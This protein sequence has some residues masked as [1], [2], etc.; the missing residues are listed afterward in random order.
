MLPDVSWSSFVMSSKTDL[1]CRISQQNVT[2]DASVCRDF[3]RNV[4]KRGRRCKFTHPPQLL[5]DKIRRSE[6]I[7]CHDYQNA[8]C[9]RP[10][11]K[12]LHYSREEEEIFRLTGR[13]PGERESTSD[14]TLPPVTNAK[15]P[16]C[17]DYLSG[18][19]I[20]GSSC[21]YRHIASHAKGQILQ[22]E[23][24]TVPRGTVSDDTYCV[25]PDFG[26]VTCTSVPSCALSSAITDGVSFGLPPSTMIT[27]SIS[28]SVSDRPSFSQS[29]KHST[30][31]AFSN[32]P[33]RTPVGDVCFG[34]YT[35]ATPV[36][37]VVGHCGLPS[38]SLQHTLYA[39]SPS[40][41][42]YAPLGSVPSTS[43]PV[44]CSSV[45]AVVA[46][47][48]QHPAVLQ[49]P[50]AV[51]NP[52]ATFLLSNTVSPI[53]SH[54]LSSSSSVSSAPALLTIPF[55][56]FECNSSASGTILS[57]HATAD[58]PAIFSNVL[59]T[60]GTVTN[61]SGAYFP[62]YNFLRITPSTSVAT[63]P[64]FPGQHVVTESTPVV[65]SSSTTAVLAAAAAAGYLAQHLPTM[66][67]NTGACTNASSDDT[68]CGLEVR[69]GPQE[70]LRV[71]N[72]QESVALAAAANIPAVSAA[73]AAAAVAAAKAF[74]A[75]T[76][77]D[78]HTLCATLNSQVIVATTV[79]SAAQ[80][81]A[82]AAVAATAAVTHSA[83]FFQLSRKRNSTTNFDSLKS[84][85]AGFSHALNSSTSAGAP[86]CQLPISQA[87]SDRTG[88]SPNTAV[89]MTNAAAAAAMAAAAVSV[90]AKQ[91]Q[92]LSEMQHSTFSE[93]SMNASPRQPKNADCQKNSYNAEN[94]RFPVT[95]GAD[96]FLES[97]R[98]P[99]SRPCFGYFQRLRDTSCVGALEDEEDDEDP[100]VSEDDPDNAMP[101]FPS[102][103]SSLHDCPRKLCKLSDRLDAVFVSP[104]DESRTASDTSPSESFD[105][106]LSPHVECRDAALITH[107]SN[108]NRHSSDRQIET[109]QLPSLS[110]AGRN[111]SVAVELGGSGCDSSR[112]TRLPS[113]QLCPR[114]HATSFARLV[115]D[116]V[117]IFPSRSP[118]GSLRRSRSMTALSTSVLKKLGPIR[119]NST[120]GF[121]MET[122]S[123]PSKPLSSGS[124]TNPQIAVTV[125]EQLCVVPSQGVHISEPKSRNYL[126]NLHDCANLKNAPRCPRT[127]VSSSKS[128]RLSKTKSNALS[129]RLNSGANPPVRRRM[130]DR[131]Q[132]IASPDS[133]LTEDYYQCGMDEVEYM[134]TEDEDI[135]EL[136]ARKSS[137]Q[138]S[139]TSQPA[140]TK[141]SKSTGATISSNS[142][143]SSTSVQ[144]QRAL[145]AENS[146]LRRK[147]FELLRQRG[148]LRAANEILLEQNA[149][150]RHSSK[151]ASAVARMAESATKIIEAHSKSRLAKP[152]AHPLSSGHLPSTTE[153]PRS[154]DH[155]SITQAA[156]AAAA[157]V[158]AAQQRPSIPPVR[159]AYVSSP[160]AATQQ[161]PPAIISSAIPGAI[162][163]SSH[164]PLTAM[165]IQPTG[166]PQTYCSVSTQLS[167]IGAQSVDSRQNTV[168]NFYEHQM[169][170]PVGSIPVSITNIPRHP[171]MTVPSTIQVCHYPISSS[172]AVFSS[173]PQITAVTPSIVPIGA[174]NAVTLLVGR[175]PAALAP[176][177]TALHLPNNTVATETVSVNF[178]PVPCVY[179][180]TPSRVF[181]SDKQYPPAG[182]VTKVEHMNSEDKASE[183]QTDSSTSGSLIQQ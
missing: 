78:E 171:S 71:D 96:V 63:L 57:P 9:R 15:P 3:L 62:S 31:P 183:Q 151:R 137:L 116:S 156:A 88:L 4:C 119:P 135:F 23:T 56:H 109:S 152:G 32:Q 50:S 81:A 107:R 180:G 2:A 89:T 76:L 27:M 124:P 164:Q 29:S 80:A 37:G 176:V 74:V 19:C 60:N 48:T 163:L 129:R 93:D 143:Y 66:A 153:A 170:H 13:L 69:Y 160:T 132:A 28:E 172:G 144:K 126:S 84:P 133:I 146:R 97:N 14:G 55:S 18:C 113:R 16:V 53:P 43:Q 72:T 121:V 106:E 7:F 168:Q 158:A 108:F 131:P 20:R 54:I 17:K 98:R 154:S 101:I 104:T 103:H 182:P 6:R 39:H 105:H 140:R 44:P 36:V 61:T 141:L 145:K 82:A 42:A 120:P 157:A 47:P 169:P 134:D 52:Q 162:A 114:R 24:S 26:P 87:E 70:D 65:S 130:R 73:A 91:R 112:D 45:L 5:C 115:S 122:V 99:R 125:D 22:C 165:H 79:A 38:Q 177:H 11:C 95:H 174:P 94:Y 68:S 83:K 8:V 127:S 10:A 59:P 136:R 123:T 33:L 30:N 40:F 64:L 128:H 139:V 175:P 110:R 90:A 85:C 77:A 118:A 111:D 58:C 147:L 117:Q 34:S 51:P 1:E 159:G 178:T 86:A 21:K 173:L 161:A 41:G 148:D 49:H 12:F 35:S 75:R 67:G 181:S 102:G 46:D 155:F 167:V 149:R 25:V 92:L 138:R 100:D 150:L 166:Q 179:H 142:S